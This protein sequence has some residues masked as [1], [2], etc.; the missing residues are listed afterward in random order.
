MIRQPQMAFL[1]F[2]FALELH[3][4]LFFLSFFFPYEPIPGSLSAV[5]GTPRLTELCLSCANRGSSFRPI[6]GAQR[7][8]VA[9]LGYNPFICLGGK[10]KSEESEVLLFIQA[11]LQPAITASQ[12]LHSNVIVDQIVIHHSLII[13]FLLVLYLFFFC[14]YICKVRCHLSLF[15]P[16]HAN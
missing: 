6:F 12:L 2:L 15:L 3:V 16:F 13:I 5:K 1:C 10:K 9:P 8:A 11:L 4:G 7:C 14:A